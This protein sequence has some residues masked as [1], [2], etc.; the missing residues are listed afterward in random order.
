MSAKVAPDE[1]IDLHEHS[2]NTLSPER[3]A[4]LAIEAR[5]T[6][7]LVKSEADGGFYIAARYDD[8]VA[9]HE[10]PAK[11]SSAPSV[12]RPI[13]SGVPPFAAL[14]MDPPEHEIWR[15]VFKELISPRTIKKITPQVLADVN[16]H[17]D[18]FIA[19]GQ[20]ELVD[21]L[22][23][24]VPVETICR[25]GGI[26]DMDVAEEIRVRA[27]ATLEAGGRDPTLFSKCLDAFGDYILPLVAER[28]ANPQD[29]FLSHIGTVE[30]G[31]A[32]MDDLTIRS[33]LFGLFAAGHHSTTSS[34][35]SLFVNVLSRPEILAKLR[36][37]PR[38]IPV[39]V[40]ESLRI[41]PPFYGFFRRVTED[42]EFQGTQLKTND[43]VLLNWYSANHDPAQ[44]EDPENF[45]LDRKMNRHVAFGWGI[46]LCVGAPLARMELKIA[47]E[48]VLLRLHDIELVQTPRRY[49]GGAGAAY[50]D[51]VHVRFTPQRSDKTE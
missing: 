32:R 22:A 28:R 12:F 14:E 48:Q 8:V 46:H 9:V 16:R 20:A 27:R 38:L 23:E 13:A 37:E 25:V 33:V 30:I 15:D 26:T 39:A 45:R 29:D 35:A 21:Q 11:F 36:A 40:E 2:W 3:A 43:S 1:K 19:D 6:A 41:A 7:G 44:F 31:G 34:M 24:R 42:N 17:I 18:G 51:A 4:E 10:C 47:L 49:F 5:E 50:L